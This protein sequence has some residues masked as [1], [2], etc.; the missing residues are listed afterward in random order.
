M[1]RQHCSPNP[2]G[3]GSPNNQSDGNFIGFSPRGGIRFQSS[4]RFQQPY[5]PHMPQAHSGMNGRGHHSAGRSPRYNPQ[6]SPRGKQENNGY[7][8]PYQSPPHCHNSFEA[9]AYNSSYFSDNRSLNQS[10]TNN[11]SYNNSGSGDQS[12]RHSNQ[13]GDR[14]KK[15]VCSG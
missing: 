3:Q 9:S 7:R 11:T 8:S 14:N 15:Q 10:S 1:F 13:K 2:Y 6:A 4:P 12:F 5:T